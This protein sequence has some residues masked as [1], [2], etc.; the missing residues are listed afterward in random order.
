[1]IKKG[2]STAELEVDEWDGEEN[3][4]SFSEN[5]EVSCSEHL[6]LLACLS[7]SL[8]LLVAPKPSKDIILLC[9]P[10]MLDGSSSSTTLTTST[11]RSRT[12]YSK[13][14]VAE[15]FS[16]YHSHSSS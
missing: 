14:L 2:K 11:M 15:E 16:M 6:L 4:E 9:W 3:L 5:Y 12:A 1:M 7:C 10:F 13:E 8:K